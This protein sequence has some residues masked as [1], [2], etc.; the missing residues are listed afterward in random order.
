MFLDLQV[1]GVPNPPHLQVKKH[2]NTFPLQVVVA[3]DSQEARVQYP[4]HLQ[5]EQIFFW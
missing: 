1:Q 5:V 3:T 4:L 2:A